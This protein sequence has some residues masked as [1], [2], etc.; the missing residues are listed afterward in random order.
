MSN[1]LEAVKEAVAAVAGY[2]TP[3]KRTWEER[4]AERERLDKEAR[5]ENQRRYEAARALDLEHLEIERRRIAAQES[6]VQTRAKL[7]RE[8]IDLRTERSEREIAALERIATVLEKFMSRV[9]QD[10]KR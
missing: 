1:E 2:V 5:E 6:D 7:M 4:E 8:D 3:P 9:E 10:A